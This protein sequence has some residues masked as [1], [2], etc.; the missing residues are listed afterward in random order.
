QLT[1][2]WN[3]FAESTI[4][5]DSNR[6]ASGA[7]LPQNAAGYTFNGTGGI[8]IDAAPTPSGGNANIPAVNFFN[9]PHTAANTITDPNFTTLNDLNVSLVMRHPHL[10]QV[11]LVLQWSRTVGGV[12][13]K[14]Q[15]TLLRNRTGADGNDIPNATNPQGVADAANMGFVPNGIVPTI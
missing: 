5:T 15:A 6:D 4:V 9:I 14:R 10:N 12:T 3:N 7:L 2:A 8:I 1:V 13:S 11:R